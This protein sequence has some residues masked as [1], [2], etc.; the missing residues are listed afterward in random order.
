RRPRRAGATR[1]AKREEHAMSPG[2]L[3]V[4]L[5]ATLA[6]L[7][8]GGAVPTIV[9][10]RDVCLEDVE[11]QPPWVRIVFDIHP[12]DGRPLSFAFPLPD[13]LSRDHVPILAAWLAATTGEQG[14]RH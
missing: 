6:R 4:A 12:N 3:S 5:E 9:G 13:T 2:A 11:G 14:A 10:V 1:A 8:R 7:A